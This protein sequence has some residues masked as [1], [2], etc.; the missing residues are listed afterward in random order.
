LLITT[1]RSPGTR[2]RNP[3]YESLAGSV[4]DSA[5]LRLFGSLPAGRTIISYYNVA[6]AAPVH[7]SFLGDEKGR[8][9]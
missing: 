3:A 7:D 5:I 2:R 1:E 4:D 8:S 6:A 9:P